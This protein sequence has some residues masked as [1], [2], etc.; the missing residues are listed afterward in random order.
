M[1][2]YFIYKLGNSSSRPIKPEAHWTSPLGYPIGTSCSVCPN[3]NPFPFPVSL[4]CSSW[5][6]HLGEWNHHSPVTQSRNPTVILNLPLFLTSHMQAVKRSPLNLLCHSLTVTTGLHIPG[7]NGRSP[8]FVWLDLFTE[9]D[10]IG[11]PFLMKTLS[12]LISVTL[13][14]FSTNLSSL[15]KHH[16][17]CLLVCCCFVFFSRTL[18]IIYFLLGISS[19]PKVQ[20]FLLCSRLIYLTYPLRLNSTWT[21]SG[22]TE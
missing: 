10:T 14:S 6:P 16:W 22:I 2:V 12:P 7:S 1:L 9:F 18:P 8:V 15:F 20:I 13:L 21:S 19:A 5:V 4:L 17:F 11:H 3:L